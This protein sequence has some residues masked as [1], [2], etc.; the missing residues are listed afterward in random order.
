VQALRSTDFDLETISLFPSLE[1]WFRFIW[2]KLHSF[3]ERIEELYARVK[4]VQGEKEFSRAVVGLGEKQFQTF[5]F[6]MR[7]QNYPR[8]LD[9][10][11]FHPP[12]KIDRFLFPEENK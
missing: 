8:G 7:K 2:A 5:L 3:G 10:V 11:L 6:P 4:Q 12:T 1:L 9:A